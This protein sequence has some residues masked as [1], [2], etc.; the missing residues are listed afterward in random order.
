MWLTVSLSLYRNQANSQSQSTSP[1]VGLR[2]IA[3]SRKPWGVKLS[4]KSD[5][6][7]RAI[8][9]LAHHSQDGAAQRVEAL[10]RE[11]NIPPNYLVQILIE[12]KSKQIVKSQRGKD[13]GYSLARRPEDIT[14]GDVLRCI[15]GDI[16]DSPALSDPDCPSALKDAWKSLQRTLDD[17]ADSINFQ[18]LLQASAKKQEM[19]YI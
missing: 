11:Q 2:D 5:Y 6:A 4:V 7:A 19:Y 8:L 9:G 17:K 14:L 13:G 3:L 10:A 1:F 15:H 12:L 16:F 18:E